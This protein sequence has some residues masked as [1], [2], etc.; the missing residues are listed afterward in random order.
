MARYRRS[1]ALCDYCQRRVWALRR[2]HF[3]TKWR[4]ET[5]GS[6]VDIVGEW[7][8]RAAEDDQRRR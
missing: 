3:F 4:C 7:E 8:V 5:C 6:R 1:P 2:N